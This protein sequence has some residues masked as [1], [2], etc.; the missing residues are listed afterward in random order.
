MVRSQ[1][2]VEFWIGSG[3]SLSSCLGSWLVVE[4]G[5]RPGFPASFTLHPVPS[6]SYLQGGG[7][8]MATPA[9]GLFSSSSF[10]PKLPEAELWCQHS[11]SVAPSHCTD[12][13]LGFL[14]HCCLPWY[15][16]SSALAIL[17]DS[18]CCL[19]Q[20]PGTCLSLMA[21]DPEGR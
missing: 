8:G 1:L 9:E 15:S 12:I 18:F 4:P 14:H 13:P 3:V 5:W 6:G 11:G 7:V 20:V 19:R 2:C 10:Q 17:T 16:I 21:P